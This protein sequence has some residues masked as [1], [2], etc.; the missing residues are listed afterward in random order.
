MF[1]MNAYL[2]APALAFLMSGTAHAALADCVMINKGT[3]IIRTMETLRDI[4]LRSGGH[5]VKKRYTFRP[6][7][8][9]SRFM[10]K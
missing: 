8:I 6:L 4:L 7:A 1:R 10:T 3:H 9:A 5:H 2:A